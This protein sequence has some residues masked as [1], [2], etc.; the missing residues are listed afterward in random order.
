VVFFL[1]AQSS[2]DA[3]LRRASMRPRGIELAD[4]G[5]A[6][7]VRELH[8]GHQSGATR[9]DDHD[10]KLMVVHTVSPASAIRRRA[11]E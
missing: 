8:R 1:V 3:T 2:R 6:G 10:I 5:D 7:V 11:E 9:S 4:D